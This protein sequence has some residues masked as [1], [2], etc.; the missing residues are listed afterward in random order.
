MAILAP[1]NTEFWYEKYLILTAQLDYDDKDLNCA[2]L[3][4]NTDEKFRLFSNLNPCASEAVETV[5][6]YVLVY[7]SSVSIFH[8]ILR[9]DYRLAHFSIHLPWPAHQPYVNWFN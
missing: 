4:W 9:S 2:Y 7:F 6:W 8:C 1:E 5:K 3:K